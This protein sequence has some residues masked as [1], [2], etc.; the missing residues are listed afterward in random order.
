VPP[1][2]SGGALVDEH[3][4]VS[5]HRVGQPERFDGAGG[6]RGIVGN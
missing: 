5:W 6:E 1:G 2:N 4:N 3:V